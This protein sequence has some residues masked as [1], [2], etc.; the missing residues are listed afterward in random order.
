MDDCHH[1]LSTPTLSI[2]THTALTFPHSILELD[3][4]LDLSSTLAARLDAGRGDTYVPYVVDLPTSTPFE[5]RLPS[6]EILRRCMVLFR[7]KLFREL[8]A[9]SV[10]G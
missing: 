10:C 9:E 6:S 8:S 2:P 3:S 5:L 4:I 7:M 1:R